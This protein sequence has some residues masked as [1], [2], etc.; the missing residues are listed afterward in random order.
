MLSFFVINRSDFISSGLGKQEGGRHRRR[1]RW[2]GTGE[3]LRSDEV[4]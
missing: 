1:N 3:H 2:R 4:C